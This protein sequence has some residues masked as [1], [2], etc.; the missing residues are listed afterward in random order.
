MS[1]TPEEQ[2]EVIKQ[3]KSLNRVV[4]AA[5]YAV[6]HAH[7]DR[8]AAP[9]CQE[10]IREASGVWRWHFRAMMY[11]LDQNGG[12]NVSGGT[13]FLLSHGRAETVENAAS[14]IRSADYARLETLAAS[15]PGQGSALS[16][17]HA[18]VDEAV[19]FRNGFDASLPYVEPRMDENLVDRDG[20]P[21]EGVTR[22]KSAAIHPHGNYRQAGNIA[23]SWSRHH[24]EEWRELGMAQEAYPGWEEGPHIA[25]HLQQ[26]GSVLGE[27]MMLTVA[28]DPSSKYRDH[29]DTMHAGGTTQRPRVF[30]NIQLSLEAFLMWTHKGPLEYDINGR[31]TLR[32]LTYN[33]DSAAGRYARAGKRALRGDVGPDDDATAFG[34]A[35]MNAAALSAR[36]WGTMDDFCYSGLLMFGLFQVFGPPPPRVPVEVIVDNRDPNT[37]FTGGFNKVSS[38]VGHWG[39]DSVWDNEGDTF[40][41]LPSVSAGSYEVSAWYTWHKNRSETVPYRVHHVGGVAEHIVN[42]RDESQAAQWVL[43]GVYELDESSY[44]EVSSENGQAVADAVRFVRR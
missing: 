27:I 22:E 2:N 19:S 34:T 4:S 16:S 7:A 28:I 35:A 24:R 18:R 6:H 3:F 44:V 9:A 25:D 17:L 15:I 13:E 5:R 41:W 32:G 12:S 14:M 8:S 30:Q 37:S 40:W 11:L 39:V 43:L 26:I 42:Q 31:E 20:A 23:N 38:A 33:F 29:L 1:L 36:A 10:F 21:R